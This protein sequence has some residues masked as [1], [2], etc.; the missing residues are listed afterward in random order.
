MAP[1]RTETACGFRR[2]RKSAPEDEACKRNENAKAPE[3]IIFLS[4]AFF[5]P[6]AIRFVK[7]YGFFK[8]KAQNFTLLAIEFH[9]GK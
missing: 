5:C 8:A 6:F 4:G 2:I 1:D 3:R 9:G 7:A